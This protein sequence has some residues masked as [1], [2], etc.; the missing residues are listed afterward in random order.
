MSSKI[1]HVLVCLLP[2]GGCAPD[3]SLARENNACTQLMRLPDAPVIDGTLE[4]GLALQPLPRRGWNTSAPFPEDFVA[5]Y[6]MAWRPDGLYAFVQITTPRVQASVIP[7]LFCGDAVELFVDADGTFSQAPAY[8][9][10]G[11]VQIVIPAPASNSDSEVADLYRTYERLG[12]WSQPSLVAR[13]TTDGYVVEALVTAS[14][15]GLA[16]WAPSGKV[17]F[18][19]AIDV[20]GMPGAS[21]DF[22]CEGRLGQFALRVDPGANPGACALP[23]CNLQSFC[24]ASLQNP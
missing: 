11:A 10:P 14:A 15:L 7:N 6:A 13:R 9:A 24:T 19:I 22:A 16:A 17:A 4:P 1:T 3:V 12:P 5:R 23:Y 21:R 2:L 8:D 20:S 18:N